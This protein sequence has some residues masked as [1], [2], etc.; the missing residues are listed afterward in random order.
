MENKVQVH[1]GCG[2]RDFGPEWIH[3]DGGDYPHLQYSNITKLPFTDNCVDVI[4]ASHVIEYFS[5]SEID[6]VLQE[7]YRVLKHKGILRLAV[8]DLTKLIQVYT[9][10]NDINTII[11]PMYGRMVMGDEI[12]Y[13]KMIYDFESLKNV[14]VKNNFSNV[15]VYDWRE[16]NHAQFDDHSQAYYPHMDK[17]NGILI[18]LNVEAEKI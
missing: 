4:Y 7:W 12:I 3:I 15:H 11:G 13:H 14:L 5:K 9:I 16:T 10:T 1:L 8:P 18:S 6:N 2:K 17:D